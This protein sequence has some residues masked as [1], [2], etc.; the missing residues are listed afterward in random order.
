ML[1]IFAVFGGSFGGFII[2]TTIINPPTQ[3]IGYCP[4]PAYIQGNDCLKTVVTVDAQGQSHSTVQ[5]AGNILGGYGRSD[6][7]AGIC[8]GIP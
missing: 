5:Q 3:V 8:K 4:P 2:N 7:S 1:V 6:C